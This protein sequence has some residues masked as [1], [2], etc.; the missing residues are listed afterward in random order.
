[1]KPNVPQAFG[2]SNAMPLA[3]HCA[4]MLSLAPFD[5]VNPATGK[6]L[7][8]VNEKR[9]FSAMVVFVHPSQKLSPIEEA[10]DILIV[11]SQNPQG[12]PAVALCQL[13]QRSRGEFY[14]CPM[15]DAFLVL[16]FNTGADGPI[17]HLNM[18]IC[19]CDEFTMW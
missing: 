3:T 5:R 1:M 2:C 11:M 15:N 7:P 9:V 6:V 8:V 12:V 16:P 13:P 4:L 18:P 10:V 17:L 14:P 19:R